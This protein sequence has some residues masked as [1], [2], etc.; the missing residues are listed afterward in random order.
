MAGVTWGNDQ[1]A[2]E[3]KVRLPVELH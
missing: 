2:F 1:L 3:I